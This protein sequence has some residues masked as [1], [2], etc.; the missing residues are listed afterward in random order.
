MVPLQLTG[1]SPALRGLTGRSIHQEVM[2]LTALRILFTWVAA[3]LFGPQGL[4]RHARTT[5]LRH[6]LEEE[7]RHIHGDKGY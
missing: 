7:V 5:I 6:I 1:Y 4:P 2:A 3:L